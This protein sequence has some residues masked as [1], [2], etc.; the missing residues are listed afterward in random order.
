MPPRTR[1]KLALYIMTITT[2]VFRSEVALLLLGHGVQVLF[3]SISVQAAA[4]MMRSVIIP[5]VLTAT[6]AGLI[7]T[8]SIDSFMWQ[9]PRLIWPE[10][11]AF[12]SNVLPSAGSQGASAWGTS[13]W[14]WYLTSALPRLAPT[15]LLLALPVFL[16]IP[17]VVRQQC[18]SLLLPAAIYIGLYSFLPHK[19]TRFIFP[20]LPTLNTALALIATYTTNRRSRSLIHKCFTYLLILATLASFLVS[21]LILLL[22]SALTYPGGTALEVLH[23]HGTNLDPPRRDIHVHLTNLAL[24]TGVTRFLEHPV[25]TTSLIYLPGST[26][27]SRPPLRSGQTRWWYDKSS[28]DTGLY[29]EK[30][31]WQRFDYVV[32]EDVRTVQGFEGVEWDTV[33]VVPG[34]G[35][36]RLVGG[37]QANK[38]AGVAELLRRMYRDGVLG[39]TA[40]ALHD[41]IKGVLCQGK[42]TG[43]SFTGGRWVEWAAEPALVVLKS[44]PAPAAQS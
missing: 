5:P 32:V 7:L 13:P 31:F 20:I 14:H 38:S 4:S 18:L 21:H 10:A 26:D 42:G 35:K 3:R 24:Q 22:L 12:L 16:L 23:N 6:V 36:L 19:E 39:R 1:L 8:V 11:A 41:T 29:L 9:S 34:L 37:R 44:K 33:G 43:V 40:I 17:S 27:G 15:P 25:P 28:N 30:G 2:V